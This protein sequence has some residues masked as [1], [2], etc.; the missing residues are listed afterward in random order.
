MPRLYIR[1]IG[2][3]PD[4]AALG[5]EPGNLQL[6]HVKHC[7]TGGQLRDLIVRNLAG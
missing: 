1:S 6:F 4:Q 5:V 7:H 2:L 3:Y